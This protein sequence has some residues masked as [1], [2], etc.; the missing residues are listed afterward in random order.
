MSNEHLHPRGDQASH[1][2]WENDLP[3]PER[4]SKPPGSVK[5]KPLLRDSQYHILQATDHDA[6]P[7]QSR[8]AGLPSK[9]SWGWS[10]E[11]LALAIVVAC[12]AAVVGL[13]LALQNRPVPDWPSGITVNAVLS[14]LVTVMKGATGIIIAE[15]LSQLKWL[16]FKRERNLIDL[17]IWDEASRGAWGARRLL[18]TPRAWYL[19]YLGAFTFLAAFIIGPSIQQT[20]EIRVRQIDSL[21]NASVPLCNNTYYSVTGLGSASGQNKLNLPMIGM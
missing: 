7:T 17:V 20:V 2:Q 6:P 5:R 4:S 1:F 21:T 3:D 14:V 15:C 18:T 19:G 16:W 8:A 9:R 13:L 11:I 10:W 12:F